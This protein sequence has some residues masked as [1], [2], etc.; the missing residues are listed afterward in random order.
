MNWYNASKKLRIV[1]L[2]NHLDEAY[3]YALALILHHNKS[4][5]EATNIA[6]QRYHI[7]E[8]NIQWLQERVKDDAPNVRASDLPR[9][10]Q[11]ITQ[12]DIDR[13]KEMIR[14]LPAY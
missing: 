4:V 5:Q 11:P 6:I 14:N 2:A 1:Q 10:F 9:A 3:W 13:S 7:Q 12:K 8:A